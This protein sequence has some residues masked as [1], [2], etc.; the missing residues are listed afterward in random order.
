MMLAVLVKVRRVAGLRHGRRE[1][2]AFKEVKRR[3]GVS[4]EGG[5]E[6]LGQALASF[7]G[8]GRWMELLMQGRGCSALWVNV[9]AKSETG[10]GKAGWT[11]C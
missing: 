6:M 4:I 8:Q 2:C 10:I 11:S 3:R 5:G 9:Y 7:R 1:E